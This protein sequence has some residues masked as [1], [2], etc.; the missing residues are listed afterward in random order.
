MPI[1][2]TLRQLRV[3]LDAYRAGRLPLHALVE[4]LDS[5]ELQ[6][7]DQAAAFVNTFRRHWQDLET[8]NAFLLEE[9]ESD[10]ALVDRSEDIE[11][12]VQSL[13][14]LIDSAL[15]EDGSDRSST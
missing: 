9:R 2:N 3:G 5:Y 15:R 14:V 10:T 1:L 13:E 4:H 12:T 11:K 7:Q 6:L 8:L